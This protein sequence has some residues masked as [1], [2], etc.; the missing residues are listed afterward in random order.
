[1][2]K[3][4][5]VKLGGSHMKWGFSVTVSYIRVG[6]TEFKQGLNYE[7]VTSKNGLVE[8]KFGATVDL[9]PSLFKDNI[10]YVEVFVASGIKKID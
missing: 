7:R 5:K 6:V 2:L 1:M 3:G 9:R 4:V 8:S 10:E